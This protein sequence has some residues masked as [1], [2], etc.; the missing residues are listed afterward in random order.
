M[1]QNTRDNIADINYLSVFATFATINSGFIYLGTP[2]PYALPLAIINL[3]A[4]II[5]NYVIEKQCQLISSAPKQDNEQKIN[6]YNK[7]L[8][9]SALP[10]IAGVPFAYYEATNVLGE[11][12]AISSEAS[13][14][15]SITVA[16]ILALATANFSREVYKQA[17]QKLDPAKSTQSCQLG[18]TTYSDLAANITATVVSSGFIYLGLPSPY[19]LPAAILH[20]VATI[21][22]HGTA[23]ITNKPQF[24]QKNNSNA[25]AHVLLTL[26]YLA[27]IP[28]I[29]FGTYS[30]ANVLGDKLNLSSESTLAISV[31]FS[32]ILAL[33]LLAAP[34]IRQAKSSNIGSNGAQ[35]RRPTLENKASRPIKRGLIAFDFDE[36]ITNQHVYEM[37]TLCGLHDTNTETQWKAIQNIKPRGLAHEWKTAFEEL[38]Y[39]GHDIAI[40]SYNPHVELIRRFLKEKIGLDEQI[41]KNIHIESWLPEEKAQ[42]SHGK[43]FHLCAAAKHFNRDPQ[44]RNIILIEDS[45]TNLQKAEEL[46]HPQYGS[47]YTDF[48]QEG[49]EAPH[50]H[51]TLAQA[52]QLSKELDEQAALQHDE[53]TD[54]IYQP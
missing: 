1:Q 5:H 38:F 8:F 17:K 15:I 6:T 16:L 48:R 12:L 13:L 24:Q 3:T 52:R 18:N 33:S 47:V 36:T 7:V 26:S 50:I 4:Y 11:K 44:D 54:L 21:I 30:M 49:N 51:Q 31:T 20:L 9:A 42:K 25:H 40:V 23:T 34:F 27:M 53:S 37:L 2:S 35:N 10:F 28:G 43:N 14:A 32:I 29:A 22:F 41:L 45:R 46:L 19:A 39:A